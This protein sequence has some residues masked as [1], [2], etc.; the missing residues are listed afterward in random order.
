[1]GSHSIT[2]VYGGD[3]NFASLTSTALSQTVQ[4]FS[5]SIASGTPASLTLLPGGTGVLSF[6]LA[7]SGGATFSAAVT[8]SLSGLPSGAT[9]L[10]TP[11]T[12][13]AGS[14]TTTVTLAIHVP[15]TTAVASPLRIRGNGIEI[16]SS[17]VAPEPLTKGDRNHGP[18]NDYK[19]APFGLAMLLLPFAGRLRR[20][21]RKLAGAGT[22]AVL[23]IM[24]FAATVG[25][26]GCGGGGFNQSPQTYSLT[27]TA[28]SGS[29]SRTTTISLEVDQPSR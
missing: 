16:A 13:A 19:L 11:A 8:L 4:D 9:Y 6:T 20:S 3:A 17:S 29:L 15:L 22:I 25:I 5:L 10:F 18:V 12:I 1:V 21:A 24:A 7:P 27:V 28:T 14:G 2:A 23:L 26:S